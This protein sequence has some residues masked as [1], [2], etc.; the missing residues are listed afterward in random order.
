[1]GRIRMESTDSHTRCLPWT[2]PCSQLGSGPQQ[3][4]QAGRA[5]KATNPTSPWEP[6]GARTASLIS[7]I[8]KLS[9]LQNSQLLGKTAEGQGR[10][11][12]GSTTL[13]Q[14]GD[15][16][17]EALRKGWESHLTRGALAMPCP[18]REPCDHLAGSSSGLPGEFRGGSDQSQKEESRK[19]AGLDWGWDAEA[20]GPPRAERVLRS[21][22]AGQ[23]WW[24][25]R[26]AALG[27]LMMSQHG[28]Q[29]RP[30][31]ASPTDAR[32]VLLHSCAGPARE[33]RPG[34][35]H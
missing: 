11:Q 27:K 15:K 14:E 26:E 34:S 4:Q 1:M 5:L 22:G 16:R 33:S 19:T 13:W 25:R 2:R 8:W 7:L 31:H 3:Q 28:S 6:R 35:A 23:S 29:D 30:Q 21:R 9:L 10:L 20:Q 32:R 12:G 17:A 24:L 18:S